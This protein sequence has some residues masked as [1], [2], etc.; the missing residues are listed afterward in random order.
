MQ[1]QILHIQWIQERQNPSRQ[2]CDTNCSR[3]YFTYAHHGTGKE[4]GCQFE[5]KC[6]QTKLLIMWQAGAGNL[7][8]PV[9]IFNCSEISLTISLTNTKVKKK[10]SVH[11]SRD[12]NFRDIDWLD[13]AQR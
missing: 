2:V 11:V 8:V 10:P 13:Q 6:S 1:L 9:K 12:F 3:G 4:L 5:L 7:V